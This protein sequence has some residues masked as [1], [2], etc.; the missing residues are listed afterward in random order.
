MKITAK[1]IESRFPH[2]SVQHAHDEHGYHCYAHRKRVDI[3]EWFYATADTLAE[4]YDRLC[5][6]R[7]AESNNENLG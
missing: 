2:I 1:Y 6:L 5:I 4:L 7:E 3:D